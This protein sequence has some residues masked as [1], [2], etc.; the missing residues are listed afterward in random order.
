[1]KN[2][3]KSQRRES[4]FVCD[5]CRLVGL[6]HFEGHEGVPFSL[7]LTP[8]WILLF[9]GPAAL[10][11][12]PSTNEFGAS[13]FNLIMAWEGSLA[14]SLPGG[15]CRATDSLALTLQEINELIAVD[16]H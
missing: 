4:N 10:Y 1:L 14:V 13:K 6:L 11:S 2:L 3:R 9:F 15:K 7:G 5:L 16:V 8:Y 12:Y